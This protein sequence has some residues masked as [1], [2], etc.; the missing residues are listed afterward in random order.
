MKKWMYNEF[1]HCG[2]DYANETQA[3]G[4]DSLHKKFR[5]YEKEFGDMLDFIGLSNTQDMSIIDIGCGTGAST[6]YAAHKFKT[7]L[8]VD[9]SDAM[10]TQ[11]RKKAS[12]DN[13]KNIIFHHGGFLT[14]R[15]SSQ[16]VDV[17]ITKHAFHHLPDFWKQIALYRINKMMKMNGILYVCDVVFNLDSNTFRDKIDNWINGF[18]E[19]GG[20]VLRTE[21][22]IHIR[23]E[24][25]TFKWILEGMFI[26]AGFMIE[27]NRSLD[28]FVTEYLCIKTQEIEYND[29]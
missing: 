21:A 16:A 2:V 12:S 18:D 15:H 9:V 7:V 5:N 6:F 10:I 25:S 11:A 1:K 28:G 26:K 3:E 13:V 27:K 24:F 4:Y 29:E 14:Y 17:I 22:E 20:K 8:A 23:D 19:I